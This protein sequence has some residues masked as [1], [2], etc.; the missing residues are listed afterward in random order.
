MTEAIPTPSSFEAALH[1][2]ADQPPLMFR[3]TPPVPSV[4]RIVHYVLYPTLVD[5]ARHV[6]AVVTDVDDAAQ[7]VDLLVMPP[8][9]VPFPVVAYYDAEG[10]SGTWH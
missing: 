8:K 2:P 3:S 6:A 9:Q 1:A 7:R 10:K 5:G 4:G